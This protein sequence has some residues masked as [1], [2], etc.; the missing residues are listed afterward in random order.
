MLT[1]WLMGFFEYFPTFSEAPLAWLLACT[2]LPASSL[3]F[4]H[5][6]LYQS[7]LLHP[8]LVYRGE[9]RHTLFT[10]ILVHKSV[11]HLAANLVFVF[12]LSYDLFGTLHQ[13][14]GKSWSILL[15]VLFTIL[16]I[17]IPNA[18]IVLR[19]RDEFVYTAV[20]ASGLMFG[21]F[22]FCYLYFPLERMRGSWI[23]LDFSYQ[24]W[25][26][27]LLLSIV[28]SFRKT[29]TNHAIHLLG[30]LLGS[31]CALMCRPAASKDL[32]SLIIQG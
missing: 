9:R 26:A 15:S 12:G 10:S 24:Y 14:F 30:F 23:P 5:K 32:I 31:A 7:L 21:L 27:G 17:G 8:Y 29:S 16:F 1:L 25:I 28:L 19:R 2:I 18:I 6:P 3:G 11:L 13:E 20:G 4:F 22:G